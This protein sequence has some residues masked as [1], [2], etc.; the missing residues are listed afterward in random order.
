MIENKKSNILV[1]NDDDIKNFVVAK[2]KIHV[3]FASIY[4]NK[5]SYEL[6]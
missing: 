3:A 4:P 5:S 6:D 1:I 2:N